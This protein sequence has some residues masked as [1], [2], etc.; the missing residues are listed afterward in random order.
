M[1]Q[2]LDPFT[3]AFGANDPDQGS[4]ANVIPFTQAARSTPNKPEPGFK[5]LDDADGRFV[6][7]RLMGVVSLARATL[8]ETERDTVHEIRLHVIEAS[9]AAYEMTLKL[10][11]TGMVPSMVGAEDVDFSGAQSSQ[12]HM[13]MLE[14][15]ETPAPQ[16]G[17]TSYS[18]A[19]CEVDKAPLDIE[20]APFAAAL[21]PLPTPAAPGP[22]RLHLFTPLPA[23]SAPD[24]DWSL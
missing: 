14:T 2:P 22:F 20:D 11:I 9:G 19:R 21:A 13:Q 3:L 17:W 5:L 1:S 6:V 7:D 10:R 18:A 12:A 23:V 24:A 16:I 8:L 4:A 15:C